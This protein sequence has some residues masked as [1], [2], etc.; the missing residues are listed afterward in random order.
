VRSRR[1]RHFSASVANEPF[2]VAVVRPIMHCALGVRSSLDASV[3]VVR[4]RSTLLQTTSPGAGDRRVVR[5]PRAG[6][7]VRSCLRAGAIHLSLRFS[8]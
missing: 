3:P 6:V 4:S 8:R 7:G 5:P 1:G 2:V